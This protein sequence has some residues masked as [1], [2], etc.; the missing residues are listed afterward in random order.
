MGVLGPQAT[1]AAALSLFFFSA[2]EVHSFRRPSWGLTLTMAFLSGARAVLWRSSVEPGLA[3][4]SAAHACPELHFRLQRPPPS[5]AAPPALYR[6]RGALLAAVYSIEGE[7]R[8]GP[9]LAS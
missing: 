9:N 8:K 1:R 7:L 6:R 3:L 4:S 5:R 2:Q